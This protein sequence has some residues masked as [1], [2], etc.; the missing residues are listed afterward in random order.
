LLE[1][2]IPSDE[3]NSQINTDEESV[4]I[5]NDKLKIKDDEKL[6]TENID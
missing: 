6:Q 4:E 2:I 3:N 1:A 5:K